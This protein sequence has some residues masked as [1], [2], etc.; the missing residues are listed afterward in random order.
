MAERRYRIPDVDVKLNEEEVAVTQ[1]RTFQRLFFLKQLGLVY[2]VYPAATH[3]RGAHSIHCLYEVQKI[4]PVIQI[5]E[6]DEDAQIVRMAALLHDIGHIPFS[7][8]LEDEHEILDKHDTDRLERVLDDLKNELKLNRAIELVDKAKSVLLAISG[9]KSGPRDWRSDLVG[10]TVCAD[11][12]AYITADAQWTGI[13]KRAGYY[14]MYDYFVRENNRLCVR[15]TKKG[16]LRTDILSAI[17]DVL[18]MRY[19]LTE[20]VIFHHG[21]C[22]ASAMLARAARLCRLSETRELTEMGDEV[23]LDYLEG[24]AKH[25]GIG[26]AIKLLHGLRS[27]RLYKR[28]FK[29]DRLQRDESDRYLGSNNFCSTWR[30]MDEVDRL[31]NEVEDENSLP[32]GSLVLWCANPKSGMKLVEVQVV[33]DNAQGLQGP[34]ELRSDL[35]KKEF[36]EV[37]RR[38]ERME[39]KYLDLWKFWIAIDRDNLSSVAGVVS[40]LERRL[41]ISCDRLFF[42]TLSNIDGFQNGW[43]KV[44]ELEE[45]AIKQV[46]MDQPAGSDKERPV[47]IEEEATFEELAASMNAETQVRQETTEDINRAKD[48]KIIHYRRSE[49]LF[50]K[51]EIAAREVGA[52]TN[53]DT[54]SETI[55]RHELA[56]SL[57]ELSD[58]EVF[59][60]VF[61][62][63]LNSK[64]G[65]QIFKEL[66]EFFKQN[67][68][69]SF[70]RHIS[71][72]HFIKSKNQTRFDKNDL[73]RWYREYNREQP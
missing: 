51:E 28:I 42:Q 33:W 24:L 25:S 64:L 16:E 40:S 1:T 30:K 52:S 56:E 23:F 11:L 34:K 10:N 12:L 37:K 47:P 38:V 41:K 2:L 29:I 5:K 46:H 9:R 19:A 21:K 8:T 66:Q 55:P 31:L 59:P 20:R 49:N 61:L 7:H 15:I 58:E 67:S 3:V 27:R 39:E 69:G 18:D 57:Q 14:R 72:L 63:Q 70:H 65:S 22:V 44:K 6:N 48:E 71:F 36:S 13:E 73:R 17:E 45:A 62:L 35:V 50:T 54:R 4:L 53:F 32:R 68:L 43:N 60:G 26:G